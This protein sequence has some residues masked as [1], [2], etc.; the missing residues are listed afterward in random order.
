MIMMTAKTVVSPAMPR[1]VRSTSMS[2]VHR[3]WPGRV[4]SLSFG[5]TF[6]E[7]LKVFLARSKKAFPLD[8]KVESLVNDRDDDI[9][10]V[11]VSVDARLDRR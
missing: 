2:S 9:E 11:F 1:R 6:L 7:I 4:F 3:P 10:R 8:L 5:E